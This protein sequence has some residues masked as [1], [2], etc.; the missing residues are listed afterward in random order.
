M[1]NIDLVQIAKIALKLL[2]IGLL[3]TV[4]MTFISHFVSMLQNIIGQMS[5][6]VQS[7]NGI[8]LGWFANTIGLVSM[9]NALMQSLYI[10][11]S[12]LISGV[13]TIIGFKYGMKLYQNLMKV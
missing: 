9:L 11:A 8:N 10:G 3:M 12:I 6:S 5:N 13:V 7:V 1:P 2:I 4:I